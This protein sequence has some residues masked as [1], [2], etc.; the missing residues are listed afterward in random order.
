VFFVFCFFPPLIRRSQETDAETSQRQVEDASRKRKTR[1]HSSTSRNAQEQLDYIGEI[2]SAYQDAVDLPPAD[3]MEQ[4]EHS[5]ILA[6]LLVYENTG[7]HLTALLDQIDP[8][9]L[10]EDVQAQIDIFDAK[11]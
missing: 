10:E 1:A 9:V 3:I 4:Y 7:Y 6:Q 11:M 5:A 8:R 2:E